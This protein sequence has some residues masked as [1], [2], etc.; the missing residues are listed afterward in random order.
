MHERLDTPPPPAWLDQS[1]ALAPGVV[2]DRRLR[3][4][5]IDEPHAISTFI[6]ISSSSLTFTLNLFSSIQQYAMYRAIAL[7]MLCIVV[8]MLLKR[9]RSLKSVYSSDHAHLCAQAGRR[10]LLLVRNRKCNR[11]DTVS[12]RELAQASLSLHSTIIY[13]QLFERASTASKYIYWVPIGRCHH[14]IW[15]VLLV[16]YH[17]CCLAFV[18]QLTVNVKDVDRRSSIISILI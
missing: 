15:C 17:V 3:Y 5:T 12:R 10:S 1:C 6:L 8:M 2:T 14:H 7:C 13:S 11:R 16:S 9:A 18:S 4:G